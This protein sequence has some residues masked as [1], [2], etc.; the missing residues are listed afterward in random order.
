MTEPDSMPEFMIRTVDLHKSFK[1]VKAVNG[2][3][4]NVRKGDIYGFL[5]PNGAGKT[6]TIKAIL[7]L[8]NQD[9]GKVYLNGM[10]TS[11]VGVEARVGIGYLPERAQFYRNLTAYQTM[12]FFAE[13]KG[14]DK[15]QCDE[16]L[17]KV[18]LES[19]R[20][21]KVGTF[22]KGMVQLLGVAQS[23]LGDPHLLILDEP[24]SGL[25]PRWA[26]V[27]KDIILEMSAKGTTVFFSSHLLFEVQELCNKV[28][29]LNR[30]QLVIEDTVENI[31]DGIQLK[32]HLILRVAKDGDVVG[33]LLRAGGFSDVTVAGNQITVSVEKTEKTKVLHIIEQAG[34][35]ILDFKTEEPSLEDA[36]L[37][38]IG[39]EAT[40]GG[41]QVDKKKPKME[42]PEEPSFA[43]PVPSDEEVD[44]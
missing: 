32:P 34:Y 33:Q 35:E 11:E 27:L 26:R 10:D 1:T 42:E 43:E 5:G 8:L 13:L 41:I 31:S 39:D 17:K 18:G 3:S 16:L 29:I 44:A 25:D 28:A 23:L 2:V 38:Y 21:A 22:S 19:W 4:L 15:G 24:T 36:F 12:E 37:G 40:A 14:V 20:D 6:T 7:G 30:G 9:A